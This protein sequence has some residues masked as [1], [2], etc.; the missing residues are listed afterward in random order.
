MRFL[1]LELADAVPD[2][3]TIWTFREALTRAKIDGKPAID[4]L[5]RAYEASLT[6]AGFLAMGGQIIDASI[7]A[8]PKQR[9]TDGEKDEIK[10]GRIPEAGEKQPAELPHRPG[11]ALD[12][13]ILEGEAL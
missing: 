12:G 2:A 1:E 7:V 9:N 13:Q 4:V 3:N 5:F 11:C 10:A 8:A 6:K